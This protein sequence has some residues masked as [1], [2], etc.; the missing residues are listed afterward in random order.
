[1]RKLNLYYR[2]YSNYVNSKKILIPEN[3]KIILAI[4]EIADIIFLQL[5]IHLSVIALQFTD[6]FDKYN[7]PNN[8][9]EAIVAQDQKNVT[10]NATVVGSSP[11]RENE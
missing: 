8:I 2:I 4:I 7:Y 10:V 3:Y 6:L 1:M 5:S 9:R 11:K